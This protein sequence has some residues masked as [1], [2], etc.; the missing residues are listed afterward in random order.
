MYFSIHYFDKFLSGTFGSEVTYVFNFD[1]YFQINTW[2]HT[3]NLVWEYSSLGNMTYVDV[4]T[5]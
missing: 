5:F 3:A 1:K 2:N 4:I